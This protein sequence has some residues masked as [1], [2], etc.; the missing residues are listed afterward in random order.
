MAILPKD[1]LAPPPD[2]NI[3]GQFLNAV[4][5]CDMP[6]IRYL[7]VAAQ[8]SRVQS[9]LWYTAK[10]PTN[11]VDLYS[12]NYEEELQAY[13]TQQIEH[14]TNDIGDWSYIGRI[15]LLQGLADET[16]C[17]R[18]IIR[19]DKSHLDTSVA[20]KRVITGAYGRVAKVIDLCLSKLETNGANGTRPGTI[21]LINEA[22]AIGLA[23]A[24]EDPGNFSILPSPLQDFHYVDMITH[25]FPKVSTSSPAQSYRS[26]IKSNEQKLRSQKFVVPLIGGIAMG[27]SYNSPH[28]PER[29]KFQT[30]QAIVEDVA[31][32][33]A[34]VTLSTLASIKSALMDAIVHQR[35]FVI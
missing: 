7:S 28:W 11:I 6:K 32:I 12:V 22:T 23:N 9:S 2:S 16:C 19:H 30:A 25:V 27:N 34:E 15:H 10:E 5:E 13:M 3:T 29:H 20:R 17:S 26:Q 33:A 1:I 14:G 18:A 8:V 31:G 21:G 24:E 4:A 35:D